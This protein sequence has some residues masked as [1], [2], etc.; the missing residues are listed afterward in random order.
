VLQQS[1]EPEH[2]KIKTR[3]FVKLIF[4]IFGQNHGVISDPMINKLTSLCL[5][6]REEETEA[7]YVKNE[8]LLFFPKADQHPAHKIA[9]FSIF[10]TM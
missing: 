8:I 3:G 10:F 7:F 2:K 1:A 9:Y 5:P 6:E 4:L